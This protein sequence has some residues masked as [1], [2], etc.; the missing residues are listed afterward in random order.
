MLHLVNRLTLFSLI[1]LLVVAP[2]R[3]DFGYASD[4]FRQTTQE[5]RGAGSVAGGENDVRA[6]EPGK[7]HRRVLADGQR[8]TYRIRLAADQF[9]KAVIEQDG[10]D[11][12]A[13]LLGP[14]GE[15]IMEFDSERRLRGRETVEQVA[16]AEGDY[17]LVLQPRQKGAQAG[18]YEIRIEELRAAT[19]NDRAL[20]EARKLYKK[21]IDL[22][23]S[24]RYDEALPHFERALEIRERRLGPDHPD[25]SQAI[26]GL[27]TLHYYKGEY[28][29]A[30]PLYQ[31]ALAIRKKSL[32]PEHPDV[33]ASLNNLANLYSNLGDYAKAKPLYQR[34]L[35]IREKSLDPEHPDVAQSLHNLAILYS[36]LGDYAKAEPTYQRALAIT[37]KSLG[38]EHL[39]VAQSLHNLASLYT[40]MG[41]YAKAEP[42]YQRALAIQEKLVGPE[43]HYVARSLDGLAFIYTNLGDYA[44]AEPLYQRALA[45]REKSLGPEHPDVAASLNNLANLYWNLGDYAKAEPLYQRALAIREKSLGPEHPDVAQSIYNLAVLYS[46]MGDYAK[47]EPL[48]QRALA[49]REKSLGPEHP[50]VAA[51]LNNLASLYTHLGDYAKAEPLYQRA[52]AIREKS[53]GPEHHDVAQS[54]HNLA[55]LYSYLGDYAKAEPTYQRALAIT[56]KSLGPEHPNVATSLNNLASLYTHLGDY[57]KA[58]PLY[59]RALAIWEKSLSPEHPNVAI[60][61]DALARLYM[62]KND[63]A[64][65]ISF[66]SRAIAVIERNL[67]PNLAICSERQKLAH[68]ATLSKQTDQTL[69][70]HLLYAPR[71][72]V[73]RSL[74]AT[75]IL[76]RKGRALDASSE[77]L[78]ALRNRFNPE[79]RAALDRLTDARSQIARLV[80]DGPQRMNA[81]QYRDRV[82]ALEEQAERFEAEISRRSD[83]FRAQSL[84]VTLEAVRAAI[85]DDAALIEFAS[86]RP[87]NP[88]AAKDDEAYGQPRYVA[89]V[90]R[91]RGEIQWKEL[92]EAKAI[93]EAAARLRKALRDPN[94][95]DVSRLARAADDKIMRPVRTLLGAMPG[96]TRRLLISPDGLLN[97]IPFAA[98]VDE[99]GRYLVERYTISYLTSGRDLL[100]LQLAPR[101]SNA[102]LIVAN[103]AFGRVETLAAPAGQD[104]GNSQSGDQVWGRI[105]PDMV[106][107]QQLPG[108]EHEAL[109]IKAVLTEASVL[110]REQATETAIKRCKAPR[111]LHIATHGFFLDDQ[112]S[113][114]TETHS[115]LGDDPQRLPMQLSKWAAKIENPLLRSGLALAGANE[116]RGGDD[117][118][119]LTAMEVA[120]LDLWGTR[121][122][123]LSA[124]D[125]GVGDVRNGEGVDGLRRALALAGSETQVLSL[126][127]V[128]DKETRYLMAGY[129]GR[130]LKGEGRGEALRQMQL[131]MLKDAKLRHP[132]YWAS[133]IQAGEWANLDGR[134]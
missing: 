37:E 101:S 51:S 114:P 110:L 80:L 83:E 112:E 40:K 111:I 7:P 102:P 16:E 123:A 125:T 41:D 33:A 90:L 117:D 124:C 77:S 18:G 131:G 103:P 32:G 44:K 66:Q 29:K 14:D 79:D 47:A 82:K 97:L 15:Q 17:R 99:R 50:D 107:F 13:R 30:E 113:P 1:G 24:G 72:P 6:L 115:P 70:L 134:R 27:A 105:D 56:E 91:R 59:Q 130:L 74:A 21:A 85:P 128:S 88:K 61:L 76:Q 9:L 78:N 100:R 57:A 2:S 35:A 68:L 43:H 48:D 12:V 73:A 25:V 89:Y 28:S 121:L 108:A 67:K 65:A 49:I 8:H 55:I 4:P 10:I 96:G 84:P 36:N 94:R 86:Y 38:P 98:L 81:G 93:D 87:F 118:G 58:E 45:I 122:V 75:L 104:S 22:R 3:E 20:Q 119:V 69:T 120:S 42:L 71:D 129:Y 106:F 127:P 63:I 132:Y 53:L 26:S 31:R 5:R 11:V 34:A 62:A 39:D 23:N 52:L 126:W 95:A 19:E 46:K 92:G 64:R 54:I 109:A 60:S 133:F 116:R